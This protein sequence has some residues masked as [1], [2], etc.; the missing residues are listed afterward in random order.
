M[1]CVQVANAE[2]GSVESMKE[3]A[4]QEPRRR[5]S[6]CF[7]RLDVHSGPPFALGPRVDQSYWGAARIF[8]TV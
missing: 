7:K 1:W 4:G 8:I 5:F 3:K 6:N 2:K